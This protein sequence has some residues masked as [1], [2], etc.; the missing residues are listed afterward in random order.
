[1]PQSNTTNFIKLLTV[2]KMASKYNMYTFAEAKDPL[3]D[4]SC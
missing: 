3:S 1:M 4:R 2:V